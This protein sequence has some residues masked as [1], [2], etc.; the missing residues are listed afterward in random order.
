[1]GQQYCVRVDG[2][3]R[4]T[5]RN[6]KHLRKFGHKVPHNPF[7]PGLPLAKA[8]VWSPIAQPLVPLVA[9]PVLIDVP[10]TGQLP[11]PEVEQVDLPV[12]APP[13]VNLPT[14]DRPASRP[15]APSTFIPASLW[16]FNSKGLKELPIPMSAGRAT[17]SGKSLDWVI[18][19]T[20]GAHIVLRT[21]W[22]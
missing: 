19:V 14:V 2:S 13:T 9:P 20:V 6:R 3:E 7:P 1:M 4:V 18:V 11:T 15:A 16:D 12:T 5:L 17:R 10:D 8:I 22:R 21:G